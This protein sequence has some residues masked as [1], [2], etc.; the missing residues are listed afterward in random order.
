MAHMTKDLSFLVQRGSIKA[1]TGDVVVSPQFCAVSRLDLEGIV[2]KFNGCYAVNNSTVAFVFENEIYVTPETNKVRETLNQAGF[3]MC[4]FKVPFS[5]WDYPRDK[6]ERWEQLREKAREA[7]EDEFMMD[8]L[9]YSQEMG[10]GE[11]ERETLK[12]CFEIPVNG[13]SVI[14]PTYVDHYFPVISAFMLDKMPFEKIGKFCK[15]NGKVVFVYQNGKTYVAKGY[16][17]VDELKSAGYKEESM[18]VPFSRGELIKDPVLR[19]RWEAL[20]KF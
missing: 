19:E 20:K 12:N 13:V 8:C 11:M 15:N 6:K 1:K 17:I 9:V 4:C 3:R 5:N 10:F 14:F 18:R 2:P 16:K 7:Q